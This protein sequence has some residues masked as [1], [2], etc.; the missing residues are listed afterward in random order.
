MAGR[1]RSRARETDLFRRLV[2][3]SLGLMCV[4]DLAGNLLFVNTAA[5]QALGFQPADGVGVNIRR[6][7]A[8]SVADEFDA[9]LQRIRDQRADSGLMRVV[10]KDGVERIW[11]YRN[12]LFE[13]PG[14]PPRVLG[15]AQDVTDRIRAEQ[16]LKESEQ[17]FRLLADTAPVLIWLS[18]PD[19]RSAFLNRAWLDFT[20]R[21]LGQGLGEGWMESVHLVDRAPFRAAVAGRAPFQTEFRLRRADGEHRWML[22]SGVPRIEPDGG[23]AGFVGSCVDITDIR[24]ARDV[25]ER[26]RDELTELVARRTAELERSNARLHA[27]M[28]QRERI[29]AEIARVRQGEPARAVEPAAPAAR[30]QRAV[31]ARTVVI[32]EPQEDVRQLLRGVLE[33]HGYRVI[34]VGDPET[35]LAIAEARTEPVHLLVVDAPAPGSSGGV[36]V[37]R[38]T[39]A[40]PGLRVLYMCDPGAV[41]EREGITDA[42]IALLRKP[43]PVASLLAKVRELLPG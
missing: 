16:A 27:E 23:F 13:E 20:G 11:L 30:E 37:E 31:G 1:P 21:P 39:E 6:F 15:H 18:D 5:A 7:L 43:F 34:D 10:A 24:Q 19:G 29:E 8:P 9:Y 40:R 32:V 2:E 38:L 12:V 22:G 41:A 25:L 33:L 17:R 35:A 36:L 28:Q 14:Q 4:H 42:G 26:A 3:H